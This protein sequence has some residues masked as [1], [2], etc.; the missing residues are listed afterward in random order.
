MTSDVKSHLNIFFD[1]M[2]ADNEEIAPIIAREELDPQDPTAIFNYLVKFT[3][4]SDLYTPFLTVLQYMMALPV[5]LDRVCCTSY[6]SSYSRTGKAV[7]VLYG[8]GGSTDIRS[9]P[10]HRCW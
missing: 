9:S 10:E 1:D 3:T 2:K 4:S 8:E 5:E 7:V 6:Y